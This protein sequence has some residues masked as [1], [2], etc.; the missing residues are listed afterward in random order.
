MTPAE[1]A[2][3]AQALIDRLAP[4]VEGVPHSIVMEAL[5][6]M[7]H[8][9]AIHNPCCLERAVS[10]VTFVAVILSNRLFLQQ[11]PRGASLH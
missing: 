11:P 7:F 4:L 3:A 10:D 1:H 2:I 8:Q 9:T 6:A 5:L